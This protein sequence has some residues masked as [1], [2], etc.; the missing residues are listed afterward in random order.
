M[1]DQQNYHLF[2]YGITLLWTV[3]F[4][5]SNLILQFVQQSL[6]KS[7]RHHHLPE[8]MVTLSDE[9]TGN[10]GLQQGSL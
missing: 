1:A 8:A 4:F 2:Q 10:K 3:R 6:V 9:E 7:I 5:P